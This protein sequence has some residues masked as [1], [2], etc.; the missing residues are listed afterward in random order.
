MEMGGSG[1]IYVNLYFA[2]RFCEWLQGCLEAQRKG[3]SVTLGVLEIQEVEIKHVCADGRL[4]LRVCGHSEA[5]IEDLVHLS[6]G[7][8]AQGSIFHLYPLG[9]PCVF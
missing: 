4:Y 5:W 3:N 7:C 1:L 6:R 2:V 9:L 8:K